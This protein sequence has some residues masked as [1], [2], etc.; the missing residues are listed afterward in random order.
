LELLTFSITYKQPGLVVFQKRKRFTKARDCWY[1]KRMV[2]LCK[3]GHDINTVGR[4]PNG[5]CAQCNRDFA[6]KW[7]QAHPEENKRRKN[8][9]QANKLYGW[10]IAE[11]DAELEKQGHACAICGRTGL[12]WGK[13]WKDTWHT[14]HKHG[15]EG[16]HRGILCATCNTALGDL[17]P[18]MDKVVEYLEKWRK[19]NET[20]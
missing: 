17:E 1:S 12:E 7:R 11:R 4:M 14:D 8:E 20:R 18:F 6:N 5:R 10:S 15:Q 3:Y 16:T 19:V 2:I 13:G 9:W